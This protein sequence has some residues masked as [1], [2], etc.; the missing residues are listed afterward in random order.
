MLCSKSGN[1]YIFRYG[2]DKIHVSERHVN[3]FLKS[4]HPKI[5]VKMFRT[6]N[7]NMMLLSKILSYPMP[8]SQKEGHKNLMEIIEQAAHQLHHTKSVSKSSYM[9]NSILNL[10]ENDMD[11]FKLIFKQVKKK[12]GG[13][14]PKVSKI[15]NEL[16]IYF[17]KS[18]RS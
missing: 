11:T 8:D 14:L 17:D 5:K 13:K 6:W 12:N 15:L 7:A 2:G 18:K 3:A 4:Y 9:N 1:K 10:Y 16:F